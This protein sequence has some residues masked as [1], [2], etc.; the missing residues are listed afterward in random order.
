VDSEFMRLVHVDDTFV[1]VDPE[2]L[3]RRLDAAG[4]ES[5]AVEVVDDRVRF[6]AH[7][8]PQA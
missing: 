5:A 7:K 8:A 2:T 6:V 4:F 3:G 1:P